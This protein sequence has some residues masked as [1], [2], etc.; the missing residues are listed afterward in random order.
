MEASDSGDYLRTDK[1]EKIK[2]QATELHR[3]IQE[4][5]S[6]CFSHP[7]FSRL[8]MHIHG[9]G[10]HTFANIGHKMA[11]DEGLEEPVS[12]TDLVRKT[13]TRKDGTFMDERAEALVLEVEQRLKRC[14]KTDL[15]LE[16][17]KMPQLL[18]QQLLSAFS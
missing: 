5:I 7:R 15:Q 3:K 17:A 8:K 6:S 10:P 18:A 2:E 13:H 14:Y 12:Y 16:I 1:P 9:A 11:I 4:R